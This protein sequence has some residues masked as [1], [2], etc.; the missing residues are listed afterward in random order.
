MLISFHFKQKAHFYIEDDSL[1]LTF[2]DGTK[3]KVYFNIVSDSILNFGKA[4]FYKTP[5]DEYSNIPY[6][7]LIGFKT[8]EKLSEDI[9]STHIHLIKINGRAKVKL[10]DQTTDLKHI[11]KFL[12]W[13]HRSQ[14]NLFLWLSEGLEFSDLLEAYKWIYD[15]GY[16]QVNLVTANQGFTDFYLVKDHFF[17]EDDLIQ[18]LLAPQ[19]TRPFLPEPEYNHKTIKIL[20]IKDSTDF[21]KLETLD[22]SSEYLLQ[23]DYQISLIDYLN[24]NLKI[25][26]LKNIQKEI[27]EFK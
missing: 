14:P 22:E 13:S 26:N 25:R 9:N 8:Q 16:S 21:E 19:R 15:S 3:E 18:K 27:K 12:D 24:L 11:P 6:Y 23:V 4:N 20:T 10:N 7:N 5:I 17:L 2:L 1:V